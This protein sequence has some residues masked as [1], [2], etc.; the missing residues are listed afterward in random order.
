MTT[1]QRK[2][3]RLIFA[4]TEIESED[5]KKIYYAEWDVCAKSRKDRGYLKWSITKYLKK[6][7]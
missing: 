2:L 6:W 3:N 5:L 7:K 1:E 4:I